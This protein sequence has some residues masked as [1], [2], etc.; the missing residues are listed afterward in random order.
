M[1]TELYK[2][3]ETLRQMYHN[4]EMTQK[5][6]AETLGTTQSTIHYWMK[7]H[8][9][10]S[11]NR[12]DS[13]KNYRYNN[14]EDQPLHDKDTLY[15]LYVEKELSTVEIGDILG[16]SHETIRKWLKKNGIKTRSR[17]EGNKIQH[18]NDAPKMHQ[19]V[20][21]YE[22]VRSRLHNKVDVISIHR[23]LAIAEH[24]I[25][26]VKDKH[27]HHKNKI[28]WDNR[29]D[30]IEVMKPTQHHKNHVENQQRSSGGEWV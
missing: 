25:E 14:S 16:F 13:L 22:E 5:E 3:A 9:I 20:K 29:P 24:G 26:E 28:P 15:E 11:R 18:I 23:L 4:E 6:I 19:N 21:G 17:K 8:N 12:S 27:V 7:K 2:D 1:N 30:N 10:K